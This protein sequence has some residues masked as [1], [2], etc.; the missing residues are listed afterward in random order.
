MT[1][2]LE[3]ALLFGALGALLTLTSNLMKRMVPLRC[4]AMG[5]NAM[6]FVQALVDRNWILAGLH[7][8]LFAANAFRLGTLWQTLRVLERARADAP[9]RDVLLPY[10]K[11]KRYKA[12]TVLFRRG[13]DAKELYYLRSGRVV[14]PELGHSVFE[15]G[16]L[17]GEVGIFA[18]DHKRPATLVC[19]TDCV[20]H[21]MTDEAV[22]TLYVQ[23]PHIAFYMVRLVVEH[24]LD[25]IRRLHLLVESEPTPDRDAMPQSALTSHG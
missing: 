11:R 4:F 14:A 15:P 24:L 2:H 17:F 22:H 9:V 13:D 25:E 6:F 3:L 21:T 5:A 19:E 20:M 23:N 8:V 16:R 1:P 10:M 12:G 7:T 18:K